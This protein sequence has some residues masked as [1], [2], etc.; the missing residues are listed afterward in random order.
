MW[1]ARGLTAC[2]VTLRYS[3]QQHPPAGEMHSEI[4]KPI[5]F[6]KYDV[7]ETTL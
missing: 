3:I 2:F 5:H 1:K 6:L 4:G 7:P